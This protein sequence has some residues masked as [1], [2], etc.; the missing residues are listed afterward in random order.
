MGVTQWIVLLSNLLLASCSLWAAI[1]VRSTYAELR[2]RLAERST[3]SLREIDAAVAAVE[4][5][6]AS[7]TTTLRRLSSRIGMQDVRARRKEASE[8]P[9]S[10]VERKAWLRK[11]LSAGNL[12]VI[13]DN[14]LAAAD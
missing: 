9:E 8:I 13:R 7:N 6:L 5:A 12:R 2:R 4:S 10:P 14:P 1:T 3:R 11:N